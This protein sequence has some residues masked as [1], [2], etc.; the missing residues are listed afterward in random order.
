MLI[1]HFFYIALRHTCFL[2]FVIFC[3]PFPAGAK[4]FILFV[5]LE[6]HRPNCLVNNLLV[7][8]KLCTK[9]FLL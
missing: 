8:L 4:I 1:L 5:S 9:K 3:N 2:Q 6:F 7:S